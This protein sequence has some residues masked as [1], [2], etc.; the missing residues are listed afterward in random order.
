MPRRQFRT[1][2]PA[3]PY[4]LNRASEYARGLA[5]WYPMIFP[6]SG[7]VYDLADSGLSLQ[8]P[9]AGSASN[10]AW[11][12]GAFDCNSAGKGADVII[13]TS[14]RID[15]P[16]TLCALVRVVGTPDQ[17]ANLIAITA[18]NTD[19]SP[20]RLSGVLNVNGQFHADWTSGGGRT[21]VNSGVN[22]SSKLNGPPF[23]V[24]W[25]DTLTFHRLYLDGS[26]VIDD[27]TAA[28]SL[29]GEYSATSLIGIGNYTPT[30]RAS[31]IQ[32]Y[33][34]RIYGRE[35]SEREIL[36]LQNPGVRFD[37]YWERRR[38]VARSMVQNADAVIAARSGVQGASAVSK[39]AHAS[40]SQRSGLLALGG[41][42]AQARLIVRPLISGLAVVARTGAAAIAARVG[43]AARP[44]EPAKRISLKVTHQPV[45]RATA[46]DKAATAATVKVEPAE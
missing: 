32:L 46:G 7:R 10:F 36:A 26:L 11:N 2:S 5:A 44:F 22:Y 6:G 31:G 9:T 21:Q 29:S 23:W 27:G 25:V 28:L 39:V 20:F 37:L 42:F 16:L 17:N 34:V 24:V 41:L 40:L 13:P 43:L 18:N 30:N 1:K 15:R 14:R 8:G 19:S 45:T 12:E 38:S 4:A 35:L 3:Y 33:D